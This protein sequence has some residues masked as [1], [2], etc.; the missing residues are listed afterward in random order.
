MFKCDI[1]GFKREE[2]FS[3]RIEDA[4]ILNIC[5]DCNERIKKAEYDYNYGN[6]RFGER[7][8][9]HEGKL[10]IEN[11]E[12]KCYNNK[13]ISKE[14]IFGELRRIFLNSSKLTLSSIKAVEET[15]IDKSE[16]GG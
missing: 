9:Y 5:L 15:I 13:G 10:F 7:N 1:C 3:F 2:G 12:L 14:E 16:N 6:L 8:Y 4:R 11:I